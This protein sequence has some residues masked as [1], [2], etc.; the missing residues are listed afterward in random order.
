M[1]E[2]INNSLQ[3]NR[4][5]SD[6]VVTH[7]FGKFLNRELAGIVVIDNAERFAEANNT[8]STTGSDLGGDTL[9]KLHSRG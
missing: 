9:A 1:V 2:D 8:T 7:S 6:A 5:V 3:L 4:V